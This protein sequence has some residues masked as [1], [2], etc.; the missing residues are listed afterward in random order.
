MCGGPTS[1]QTA[2]QQAQADFYQKQISAYDTAYSQFKDLQAQIKS[3]LQPILQAG[4]GQFGYT[5]DETTALRTQAT[6]GTSEAYAGA[7]R[8]LQQRIATLG[9]GTSNVNMTGGPMAQVSGELASTAAQESSR[10]NLGITTS[11]YDLGRQMWQ[12]AISGTQALA[13]GWNPNAF[14]ATTINAGT[15]AGNEANVIAQ[16]RNQ[17]WGSILGAVGGIGGGMAGGWMMK[18][19]PG[20]GSAS[21]SPGGS[22]TPPQQVV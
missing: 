13:Q 16:Q 6:Q 11:G 21:S 4:P 19:M 8:A 15:A 20:I 17:M 10:E 7:Q 22:F 2:N 12:N 18:G 3:Q 14:G 5:P 9:G 1:A